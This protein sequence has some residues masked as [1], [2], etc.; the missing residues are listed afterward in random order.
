VKAIEGLLLTREEAA[1][2]AL[3]ARAGADALQRRN[4]AIPAA[5]VR[6]VEQLAEFGR[7]TPDV[8]D[9]GIAEPANPDGCP[10]PASSGPRIGVTAAATRL[11]VSPQAVRRW[12]RRGDLSARR[13]RPGGPWTIDTRSADALAARRARE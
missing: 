6:L 12:C 11:G 4:G 3:L 13:D 9:S 1:A 7:R 2:V 5:A 8:Q 10:D